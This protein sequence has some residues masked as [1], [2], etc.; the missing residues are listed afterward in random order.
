MI[1]W[2]KNLISEVNDE[3]NF[4]L[5]FGVQNITPNNYQNSVIHY[6]IYVYPKLAYITLLCGEYFERYAEMWKY[7]LRLNHY[8]PDI[9]NQVGE[10]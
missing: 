1:Q 7:V 10:I 4:Q 5:G 9:C 3:L 2:K 8:D 6:L